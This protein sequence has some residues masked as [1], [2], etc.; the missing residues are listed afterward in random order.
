MTTHT[1]PAGT[2]TDGAGRAAAPPVPYELSIVVPTLDEAG[3]IEPLL[4]GLD[5][6]LAGFAWEVVFVD[7]DS[8]DGTWERLLEVARTR[9]NV[10]VI[11]RVGRRGLASACIEGMLATSAPCVAV[12]DADLQHDEHLLPTMLRRLE[13]E[14]LDIVVAS[15]FAA[16]ATLDSFSWR[17]ERLSRLANRVS[18]LLT[19]AE[20]RDPMS[21][22]FMLRRELL[23]EVVHRLSGHGF[24]L[25]LDI[26]AS[27][28]RPLRFAEVP[29]HFRRRHSGTSK[30]DTLVALE[31]ARL[32]VDKTI[33]RTL[34][35]RFVLFAL[36]GLSG[37]GV[38][39]AVLG[40]TF[41]GV[42]VPFVWAQG[43]AVWAAMT[44][45]FFLNN[46]FTYRD[47]RL[48]GLAVLKGLLSFYA[49]CSL[50]A[51]INVE[52][53]DRMYVTGLPWA[54]AGLA[55]AVVGAVW[56]YGV[57]QVLT[58]RAHR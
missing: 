49:A 27:A 19:G 58:W 51:V 26:F 31:F 45:N 54:L 38:H 9:A 40:L 18:R 32:V 3:N 29:L 57:T 10:R 28:R 47:Q 46:W 35:T 48:R 5:G 44:W 36:V 34:P 4:A 42:V 24:K 30:L 56:N 43:L 55:G 8:S 37:V 23:D 22:Y 41:R 6:A 25:L 53:A 12:M 2:R 1:S 15:R 16:G 52:V 14:A 50:G 21:G 20:L 11:R 33:G 39:L 17:R 13:S 7:D